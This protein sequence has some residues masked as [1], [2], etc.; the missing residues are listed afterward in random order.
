MRFRIAAEHA[1]DP[2]QSLHDVAKKLGTTKD[3]VSAVY[4]Q[5]S[6]RVGKSGTDG[7]SVDATTHN[8]VRKYV[9]KTPN[10]KACRFISLM[11]GKLVTCDKPTIDGKT[12]CSDCDAKTKKAA[13]GYW[14]RPK[15]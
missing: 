3:Y 10:N 15:F 1:R 12:Y 6:L 4:S 2:D 9:F 5:L 14:A 7:R 13:P 8:Q 11:N